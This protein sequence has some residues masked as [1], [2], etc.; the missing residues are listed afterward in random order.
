MG[1]RTN[2]EKRFYNRLCDSTMNN[3]CIRESFGFDSP[4]HYSNNF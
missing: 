2:E 3:E 4:W 1:F